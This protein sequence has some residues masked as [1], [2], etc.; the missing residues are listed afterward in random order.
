MSDSDNFDLRALLASWP[1]DPDDDARVVRVAGGR[2]VL[3]VRTPLGL[4]QY[5][6]DH[7]PDG[8]RPHGAES[9][10]TFHLD[11]FRHSQAQVEPEPFALTPAD[12]AE[13]I[14]E[15]T[16]YYY[17]YVR[18][19]QLQ[20][21]A[22]ALRDTARNLQVF[23]FVRRHAAN[24][25]DR[26]YLEK[27]RPYLVRMNGVAKALLHMEKNRHAAA[28]AAVTRTI[29]AIEALQEMDDEVFDLERESS[30]EALRDLARQIQRDRPVSPAER[31]ERQ[32]QAAVNAQEFE[33][34]AELRDRLRALKGTPLTP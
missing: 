19:F 9:E 7:R 15:S 14:S 23:D 17:R 4:E 27:W 25:E 13:L 5:E 30:L 1:Y 26:D 3:Q 31:L 33:R 18:L 12:C 24:A 32:L 10:F 2:E 34:A 16:L 8:L 29:A 20:D 21:W 22:R 11:R 28:L 6:L